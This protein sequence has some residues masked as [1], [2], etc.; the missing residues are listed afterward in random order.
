MVAKLDEGGGWWT[1]LVGGASVGFGLGLVLIGL[2]YYYFAPSA[3]CHLNLFFITWSLVI[4]LL[5]V[6]VLFV[7]NR[8][9]TAGLLTSGAVFLYTSFLLYSALNSEPPDS[10]CIRDGGGT[11]SWIQVSSKL[12]EA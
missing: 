3:G 10:S 1:L 2:S 12:P 4:M 9:P 6:G 5:L 7:P 11:S 8:A